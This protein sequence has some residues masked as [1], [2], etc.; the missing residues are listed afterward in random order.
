M[1]LKPLTSLLGLAFEGRRVSAALARRKGSGCC[2]KRSARFSL[3]LDP[4]NDAPDLVGRELRKRLDE[5]GLKERRCLVCLPLDWAL[6]ASFEMPEL[7]EEDTQSFLE[8]RAERE[9]PFPIDEIRI[10]VSRYLTPSGKRGATLAA[11]P[12]ARIAALQAALKSAGLKAVSITL[13][14]T[15][16][17]GGGPRDSGCGIMLSGSEKC[18][19]LVV[20][21]GEG[22]F[23]VRRMAE[24]AMN[25]KR[26]GP[27]RTDVAARQLRISLGQLPEDVRSRITSARVYGMREVAEALTPALDAELSRMGLN[28][29]VSRGKWEDF[30]GISGV[31]EPEVNTLVAAAAARRMACRPQQFEFAEDWRPKRKGADIQRLKKSGIW[32]GAAAAVVTLALAA[33][34]VLQIVK[35][36]T[37]ETEWNTIRPDVLQIETLQS[38]IRAIRPWDRETPPALEIMKM[39]AEAFPEYG[40]VWATS[41]KIESGTDVTFSGRSTN[42][43]ELSRMLDQ[44]RETEGVEN[45]H[46]SQVQ[47]GSSHGDSTT[48]LLSFQWKTEAGDESD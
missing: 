16:L 26:G 4:L 23:S 15:A 22:I 36:S 33:A 12:R 11:I 8:L 19:D 24:F 5:S 37:L 38:R 14:A 31:E 20:A 40:T 30:P 46:V 32:A 10:G 28:V 41:L 6:T 1:K 34:V 47:T 13:G 21:A 39:L 17:A 9:F 42:S 48:F 18:L 7:S 3:S 35:L 27:I 44:L 43:A 2:V 29:G 25:G 45:F